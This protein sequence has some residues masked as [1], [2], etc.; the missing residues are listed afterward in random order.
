MNKRLCFRFKQSLKVGIPSRTPFMRC[1]P[2][3]QCTYLVFF[4]SHVTKDHIFVDLIQNWSGSCNGNIHVAIYTIETIDNRHTQINDCFSFFSTNS[5]ILFH[6][7]LKC[8]LSRENKILFLEQLSCC[9]SIKSCF[10][11][12]VCNFFFLIGRRNF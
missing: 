11:V 1:R 8:S 12:I 4:V 2:K 10:C 6:Q 3:L 7:I 9:S 5:F